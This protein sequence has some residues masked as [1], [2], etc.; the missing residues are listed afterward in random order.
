MTPTRVLIVDDS[1]TVRGLIRILLT[2]DPAIEI[3]GEAAD[4]LEARAAIKATDP[5]VIT[6][7]VEMPKMNGLDFLDRLMRLRPTPVIMVSSLTA[8]GA[9]TAIAALEMGAFDCVGK[10]GSGEQEQFG[11]VL[12]AKV[13]AAAGLRGRPRRESARQPAAERQPY[14]SD[15]RIVAIGASTGGVEALIA[16]LS[17]FPANGP[18]TVITQHM[19]ATFTKSFAG[20]LDRLCR[21]AVCEAY[22]GAPLTPGA[23]YLAPGGAAHLR[24]EAGAPPRCRLVKSAPVN[25]H[26]PSVDVLFTSVTDAVGAR[27][28]GAILTGMGRDGAEGLLAMRSAGCQT[29]GQSESSCLIYGMP[30]IA[31][32]LGATQKQVS[33]ATMA[34]EILRATCAA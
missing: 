9:E 8:A 27:A 18:P 33:L 6:L 28:V 1:A 23:V 21:P 15:G 4:P 16:V 17:Q 14:R 10:P 32:E 12:L 25:G 2:R 11:D 20:R 7:D 3:V 26:R 13:K 29:F 24:V 34:S 30:K 19:P 5:D 31:F 22:D